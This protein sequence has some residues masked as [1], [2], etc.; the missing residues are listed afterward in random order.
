VLFD[1]TILE[2]LTSFRQDESTDRALKIAAQLGL[3]RRVALLPDGYETRL[4]DGV[5][6]SMPPGMRQQIGIVRS[7]ATD[8]SII[9]FDEA[10]ANLDA[11][12]DELLNKL[13][14]A[15]RGRRTVVIVSHRPATLMVTDRNYHL[16]DG[17][18]VLQDQL[19]YGPFRVGPK[20]PAGGAQ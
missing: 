17:K 20:G 6:E 2:N 1:G 16:V 19:P 15:K 9:L 4:G 10:N 18:L 8:P 13:L 11:A 5:A 14:K 7:L 3:D 12:D